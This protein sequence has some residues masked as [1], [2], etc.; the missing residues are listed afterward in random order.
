MQLTPEAMRALQAQEQCLVADSL[1]NAR[2]AVLEMLAPRLQLIEEGY[3]GFNLI[4]DRKQVFAVAQ[5]L[6][7]VNLDGLQGD[8]LQ[9][10]CDHSQLFVGTSVADLKYRIDAAREEKGLAQRVRNSRMLRLPRRVARLLITWSARVK[11]AFVSGGAW[12]RRVIHA[13]PG[14]A[15]RLACANCAL[16]HDTLASIAHF[17]QFTV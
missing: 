6:G 5:T 1:E 9:K 14:Q 7:A 12:P 16:F 10:H 4:A 8:A 2:Q 11:L 3:H 13:P 15:R 17:R